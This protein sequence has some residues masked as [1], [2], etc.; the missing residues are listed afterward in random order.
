MPLPTSE[1]AKPDELSGNP[2]NIFAASCFSD[3]GGDYHDSH[4]SPFH[5]ID[6][7]VA[8]TY[9][10]YA[11]ISREIVV[12]RFPAQ[13]RVRSQAINF[14]GKFLTDAP[15]PNPREHPARPRRNGNPI[16]QKPS[17]FLTCSHGIALPSSI[18]FTPCRK[19]AIIFGSDM[20]SMV[21]TTDS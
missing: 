3:S 16:S 2:I 6:N 15:I 20:I 13:L 8:L 21:S 17:S 7:P 12:E 18:S 19:A 9:R 1:Q 14:L 11:V 5:A 10:T 4:D